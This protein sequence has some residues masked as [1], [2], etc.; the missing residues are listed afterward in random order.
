MSIQKLV[1]C[2]YCGCKNYIRATETTQQDIVLCENEDEQSCG[3]YFVVFSKM[4][5]TAKAMKIEGL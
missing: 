4:E 2:P 5:V 3:R 1:R